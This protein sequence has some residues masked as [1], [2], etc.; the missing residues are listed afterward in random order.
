MK[1]G[2]FDAYIL[3][4]SDPHL[5]EYIPDYWR[6]INWLTGFTGSAAT[7]VVTQC[8]AGLWT[9][10]RYLIQAGNQLAGSGILVMNTSQNDRS[11]YIRWLADNIERGGI[12]GIDGRT[13]PLNIYNK[14]RQACS[15]KNILI[16]TE[17]DLISSLWTNRPPLSLT[18]A[19]DHPVEFSGKGRAEK[20]AEVR[21]A[22]IRKGVEYH[23]L[24][25]PDDIMW[26]LNIRARDVKYNPVLL[27]FAVVGM[28]QILLFADEDKIPD[29]I[30][31]DFDK[32]NIV[33]L[34]Y[35]EVAGMISTLRS[36]SGILI[37]PDTTSVALYNALDKGLKIIEEVSIPARLKA[38]KNRTEISNVG[39]AMIRDGVA[40]TKFFYWI[41][42]HS[43]A[44]PMSE[45]SLM[46]ML[47][48]FRSEQDNF[49][50]LSFSSI[51]AW[52]D[53]AAL[54]H[55][56]ATSE[57]D[58]II[59]QSGL[60]L[61]DSGSHYL[62]G[63]TDITRT[64]VVGEPTEKQKRDFTLVLKG[65]I[66]LAMAKFP[67]GTFGY[68]LDILA[69]KSLWEN[70]LNY[71]HGTGHGVGYCLN[72]HEGSYGISQSGWT[73]P[74]NYIKPGMIISNEPAI[75]RPGE[76][77]IRTENLLLCFE[78]EE[79]ESGKYLKFDT[80]SL[81]FIDKALIDKSLLD[82]NEI[83]WLNKYHSEV[84]EKLSPHLSAEQS[85]WLQEK[86]APL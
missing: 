69:R 61:V 49:L 79:T 76:Y 75:Y 24:A 31:R 8:F 14:I 58:S 64:V 50:S 18:P 37:S 36:G 3:P 46:D 82:K 4:S 85:T 41:E 39:R 67:S 59:G 78:D 51:I 60:L 81:C 7:V 21:E 74:G 19:M 77:G 40:L 52:N 27:S 9:D 45:L 83:S 23:L 57:T 30:A 17:A 16:D 12:V 62:D 84:F 26:L 33:I 29:R 73:D 43:P 55:Y 54:P 66:G 80:L 86:T 48:H 10:S 44:V 34:P 5:G 38:V 20:L 11:G 72:V 13:F 53:H 68:Q 1:E 65:M 35:E 2:G 70:G 71:G 22:M 28:D 56:G 42:R 47:F 32:N 25:S 15:D 6:L 63:T